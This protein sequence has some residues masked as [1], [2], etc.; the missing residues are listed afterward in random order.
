MGS[1]FYNGLLLLSHTLQKLIPSCCHSLG[2]QEVIAYEHLATSGERRSRYWNQ[3][4]PTEATLS[5]SIL[6]S[7]QVIF[8][9]CVNFVAR[10][11]Q[12]G[13]LCQCLN[14]LSSI[15]IW[16]LS[17][18]SFIIVDTLKENHL[19]K[20][21]KIQQWIYLAK[22]G[23]ILLDDILLV[24]VSCWKPMCRMSMNRN[25]TLITLRIILGEPIYGQLDDW[26]GGINR[27]KNFALIRLAFYYHSYYSLPFGVV[28]LR[29]GS[30]GNYYY[31]C[32][33]LNEL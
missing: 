17:V 4:S 23:L 3:P 32:L 2:D 33:F 29:L 13:S 11:G 12:F 6:V 28:Q 10:I 15:F 25:W 22:E 9:F 27:L 16:Y 1:D 30:L 5:L 18:R 19:K 21:S 14:F 20:K 24:L 31:Q 26:Y 8:F 7:L